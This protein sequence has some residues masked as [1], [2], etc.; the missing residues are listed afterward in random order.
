MTISIRIIVSFLSLMVFASFANFAQNEWSNQ[1]ILFSE[2][3]ISIVFLF[4]SLNIIIQKIKNKKQIQ[5]NLFE[6]F[7]LCLIFLGLVFRNM[8]WPGANILLVIPTMLLF[9]FYTWH[10][11]RFFKTK[12]SK[13]KFI[14]T[15]LTFGSI[16]TLITGIAVVFKMMHWPY[17]NALIYVSITSTILMILGSLKWAF[18]FDGEKISLIKSLGLIKNYLILLY[19]VCFTMSVYFTLVENNLAPRF[20]SQNRPDCIQKERDKSVDPSEA[21]E[22]VRKSREIARGYETFIENCEKSGVLK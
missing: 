4:Q 17:A 22:A 18:D 20:Y 3:A 16:I 12:F 5:A 21:E 9:P 10:I 1:L 8:Y 19:F 6:N 2:V 7:M 14:I 15:L 13:G 11:F